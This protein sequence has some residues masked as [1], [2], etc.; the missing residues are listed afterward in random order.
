M[1]CP[2]CKTPVSGSA[3]YC[4]FCGTAFTRIGR[5]TVH[6]SASQ[7]A[8][9][10]ALIR[11]KR[12]FYSL[13]VVLAASVFCAVLLSPADFRENAPA[14]AAIASPFVTA[15]PTLPAPSETPS[16][17][18]TPSPAPSAALS[19]EP[20]PTETQ[21]TGSA[22]SDR[23]GTYPVVMFLSEVDSTNPDT[24]AAAEAIMDERFDGVMTLAIDSLGD[25][26][27]QIDQ[28]FFSPNAI[29]VSAF[30][31]SDNV[32][33]GNTLYGVSNEES[34]VLTVICVC[35]EDGVSG[36]IWMDNDE[37]HIEFLYFG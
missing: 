19:P 21:G 32:T 17:A 3:E 18:P 36:F 14:S 1:V 9:K 20:S 35:A 12:F 23:S 31:D 28:G 34:F 4:I 24:K 27:I 37:T 13:A 25:G 11:A 10:P 15:S 26:T 30:I 8:R 2:R 33:S 5:R 16:A 22:F 6:Y 7:P 29:L